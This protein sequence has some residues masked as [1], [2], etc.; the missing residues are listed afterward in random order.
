MTPTSRIA[1][2]QAPWLLVVFVLILVA[3]GVSA[4]MFTWI[5]ASSPSTVGYSQFLDDVARGDVTRVVQTGTRLN[6]TEADGAVYQVIVPSVLTAVYDEIQ[7]VA[8]AGKVAIPEF[9]ADAAP[10]TSWIGLVLTFLLPLAVVVLLVVLVIRVFS[11]PPRARPDLVARLR[12]LEEAHQAG[13][14]TDEERALQRA[15]I[16]GEA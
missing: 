5:S 12:A 14:I 10:D 9:A 13:L 8:T 1:R 15:R 11:G 16:L 4:L 3:V 6:V 2:P 7:Q